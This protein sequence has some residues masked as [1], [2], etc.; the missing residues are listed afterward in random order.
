MHGQ[1]IAAAAHRR[2]Q[3]G[4]HG[5]GRADGAAGGVPPGV[6]RLH[7]APAVMVDGRGL[8]DELAAGCPD[9][10]AVRGRGA[11]TVDIAAGRPARVAARRVLIRGAA[12]ALVSERAEVRDVPGRGELKVDLEYVRGLC[13]LTVEMRDLAGGIGRVGSGSAVGSSGFLRPVGRCV[14]A[15]GAVVRQRVG[16]VV[17]VGGEVGRRQGGRVD[18]RG[19]LA[20]HHVAE[21]LRDLL[22]VAHRAGGLVD[23]PGGVLHGVIAGVDV[24]LE[25]L[26]AVSPPVRRPSRTARRVPSALQPSERSAAASARRGPW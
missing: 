8:H 11:V 18:R 9:Q 19:D 23:D 2:R 7:H 22:H 14:A 15:V 1:R 17:G 21:V 4:R 10:V 12:A 26:E 5:A 24:V 6:Q 16:Q 25:R 20:V 3:R 13:Q